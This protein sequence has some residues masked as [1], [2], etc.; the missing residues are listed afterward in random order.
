MFEGVDFLIE[1]LEFLLQGFDLGSFLP[2]DFLV[3]G[4]VFDCCP[5]LFLA[6]PV[7]VGEMFV[8]RSE[9]EIG[10]FEGGYLLFEMLDLS[11]L[12]LKVP[13]QVV[14]AFILLH[15]PV[16]LCLVDIDLKVSSEQMVLVAQLLFQPGDLCV[17]RLF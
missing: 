4:A 17:I 6:K 15:C 5:I 1:E 9:L 8:L 14:H 2:L 7:L 3:L 11:I 12:T 13:Q 10:L 16:S